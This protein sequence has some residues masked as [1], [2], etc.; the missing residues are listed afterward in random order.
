[1]PSKDVKAE[2]K[3]KL[4]MM[5]RFYRYGKMHPGDVIAYVLMVVGIILAFFF[6]FFGGLIIGIIGAIYFSEEILE[7]AINIKKYAQHTGWV[8][9]LILGGIL[10]GFLLEAPGIIIG[11]AGVVFIK[12]V[13]ENK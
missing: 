8:R 4:S 6:P 2:K 5:N 13:L 12:Y 1:M 3:N 7:L 11:A 10:L 9:S